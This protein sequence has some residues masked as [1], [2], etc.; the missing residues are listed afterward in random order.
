M[1]NSAGTPAPVGAAGRPPAPGSQPAACSAA[2]PRRTVCRARPERSCSSPGGG[3][4]CSPSAPNC[5][6]IQSS[7]AVV[8]MLGSRS[9]EPGTKTTLGPTCHPRS[10]TRYFH[11]AAAFP[12]ETSKFAYPWRPWSVQNLMFQPVRGPIWVEWREIW[13]VRGLQ[14]GGSGG[15]VSFCLPGQSGGMAKSDDS[16]G[17]GHGYPA[18]GMATLPGVWLPGRVYGCRAGWRNAGATGVFYART[19]PGRAPGRTHPPNRPPDPPG[20]T[21]VTAAVLPRGGCRFF[22][23]GAGQGSSPGRW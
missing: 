12:P 7:L 10:S 9:R 11:I 17:R 2:S 19:V 5:R 8:P 6:I 22:A 16:P 13:G 1:S 21:L 23:Y 20:P 4:A 15:I 14:G 3:V 18:G